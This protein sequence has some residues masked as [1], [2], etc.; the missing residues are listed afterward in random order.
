[1]ALNKKKKRRSRSRAKVVARPPK[2]SL[3]RN[4]RERSLPINAVTVLTA[5][6]VLSIVA[7]LVWAAY[8]ALVPPPVPGLATF[9]SQTADARTALGDLSK[10]LRAQIDTVVSGEGDRAAVAAAASDLS[11]TIPEST[12]G[13]AEPVPG[14]D[15]AIE[16][17]RANYRA[18]ADLLAES[19]RILELAARTDDQALAV[20][21]GRKAG[22]V[23]QV[24]QAADESGDGMIAAI[25]DRSDFVPG[26]DDVADPPTPD[27]FVEEPP[28]LAV[29]PAE[30]TPT[31][32]VANGVQDDKPW[33][34]AADGAMAPVKT[35][36]DTMSPAVS[37]WES[38]ADGAALTAAADGW[39]TAV[40]T[41]QKSIAA[42]KRPRTI[43]D[44][45][46]SLR[47]VLWVY[48]EATRSFASAGSVPG[49]AGALAD[50]GRRL[51][52]IGD[53]WGASLDKRVSDETSLTLVV[54][55]Q[56]GFDTS[57]VRPE[58]GGGEADE[59]PGPVGPAPQLQPQGGAGPPG[60]PSV[61]V[62]PSGQGGG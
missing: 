12:K 15:G 60:A 62:A 51:R 23:W 26:A 9:E 58:S 24:A 55:S 31:I 21:L 35:A 40:V 47:N 54:P 7:V 28:L 30:N 2:E 33:V 37:A 41:A 42:Q 1:M 20:Q 43:A 29:P 45:S 56:S 4:A 38:S 53:L 25:G 39:Y 49:V 17:A 59:S 36:L 19:A 3:A 61:P 6:L 22:R 57:L 16:V 27:P 13:L 48:D 11:T 44:V 14:A 46:S 18:A 10:D 34:R 50:S 5:L 52:L 32:E 8:R